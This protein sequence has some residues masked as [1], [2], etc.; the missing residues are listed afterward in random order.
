[1]PKE[2]TPLLTNQETLA[3][4]AYSSLLFFLMSDLY[5]PWVSNVPHPLSQPGALSR[6]RLRHTSVV[7][8]GKALP[9]TSQPVANFFIGSKFVSLRLRAE[10][11]FCYLPSGK[12]FKSRVEL[13]F[14]FCYRTVEWTLYSR[15]KA[16]FTSP[17]GMKQVKLS[18]A[19]A[20]LLSCEAMGRK[21]Q[22]GLC[23]N[24]MCGML[25]AF[26]ER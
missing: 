26:A 3:Q 11:S 24:Q 22:Q 1:M 13:R 21:T 8:T 20:F 7:F 25:V 4:K 6:S 14:Y 19:Q 18:L 17:A 16:C 2:V 15:G 23:S 9:W 12:I 5:P 10:K